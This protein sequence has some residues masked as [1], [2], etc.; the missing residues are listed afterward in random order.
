VFSGVVATRVRLTITALTLCVFAA[1]SGVLLASR[2]AD[3]DGLE[4]TNGWAGTLR[5]PNQPVP[6]FE[7]KDQDGKTVTAASLRGK[8]V[9]FAF[10]YSTCEDTCPA[11][12]QTIRGALDDLGGGDDDVHVIGIS[13][14]PDNDTPKRAAAFLLEQSMTGRMRFLLG[15]RAE[16]EPVWKA[17]G[18]RPQADDLEHSVHTVVADR[19]GVQRLGFP[20]N[21]LTEQALAHDLARL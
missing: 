11:Q 12:V 3:G 16:L 10:V 2:P 19:D 9:V 15:T 5:P 17:F 6:D 4:L 8:P 18:V 21:L 7:L 1:V 14:D 20:V 13:V